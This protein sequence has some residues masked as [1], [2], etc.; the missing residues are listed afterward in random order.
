MNLPTIATRAAVAFL[1]VFGLM[2]IVGECF[3]RGFDA[4][5]WWVDWRPLGNFFGPA[6]IAVACVLL[7]GFTIRPRMRRWRLVATRL[8]TAALLLLAVIDTARFYVLLIDRVI[9]SVFPLPFSLL[10]IAGLTWA[11]LSFRQRPPTGEPAPRVS[12]RRQLTFAAVFLV[13]LGAFMVAQMYCFG[14]TDYRVK[15]ADAIVVLGAGV[16]ASGSCSDALRDRVVTA[17]GLYRDGY[18]QR[19]IFSGGQGSGPVHETAAMKALAVSCG[20]PAEAILCDD[21][22]V[23][24]QATVDNTIPLLRTLHARPARVL[25]VSHFYHLPRVKMAYQ[26]AG[27]DIRTVPAEEAWPLRGLTYFMA[28]EAVAL[29]AYYLRPFAD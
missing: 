25:V 13:Y 17:C 2:N 27:W 3:H 5:L 6:L 21:E 29:W 18:A 11:I 8:T 28:R 23:N 4:N 7:L 1:G 15:G 12:L 14:K 10:V 22:G 20:V 26:R 16:T 19:L 24:T 9:V